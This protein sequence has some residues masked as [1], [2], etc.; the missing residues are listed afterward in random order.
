MIALFIGGVASLPCARAV[1][2]RSTSQPLIARAP[3]ESAEPSVDRRQL[4]RLPPI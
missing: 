1:L 3:I 4:N 2:A